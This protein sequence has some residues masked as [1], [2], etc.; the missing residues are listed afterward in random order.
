MARCGG[1][2]DLNDVMWFA[3]GMGLDD[4]EERDAERSGGESGLDINEVR[5]FVFTVPEEMN[6]KAKT[7]GMWRAFPALRPREYA[8]VRG[9]MLEYT[10]RHYEEIKKRVREAMRGAPLARR[11]PAPCS[12]VSRDEG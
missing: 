3:T 8:E 11:A 12:A 2:E 5:Y 1:M 6:E 4:F 7:E 9:E 10:M